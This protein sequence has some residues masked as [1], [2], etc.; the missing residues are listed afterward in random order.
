MVLPTALASSAPVKIRRWRTSA[1]AGR[2]TRR[3]RTTTLPALSR[4]RLARGSKISR[5][6]GSTVTP[7]TRVSTSSVMGRVTTATVSGPGT[8]PRQDAGSLQRAVAARAVAGAE[9]EAVVVEVA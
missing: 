2:M 5:P 4:R 1:E 3:P 6:P 8:P 9:V 7:A